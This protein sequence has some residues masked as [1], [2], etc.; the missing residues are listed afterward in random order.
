MTI[1]KTVT[2]S[3]GE[4]IEFNDLIEEAAQAKVWK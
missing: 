1:D 3:T 2:D 4:E